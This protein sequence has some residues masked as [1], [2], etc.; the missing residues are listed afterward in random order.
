MQITFDCSKSGKFWW[1]LGAVVAICFGVWYMVTQ[2]DPTLL[3]AREYVETDPLVVE[4]LGPIV[5]T[6]LYKVRYGDF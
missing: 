5:D 2:Q 4:K 6:T 3:A 1:M